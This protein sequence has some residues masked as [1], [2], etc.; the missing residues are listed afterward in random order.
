MRIELLI[1]I[2]YKGYSLWLVA[3]TNDKYTSQLQWVNEHL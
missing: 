2:I 3:F 1:K